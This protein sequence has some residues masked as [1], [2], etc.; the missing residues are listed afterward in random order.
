[1]L[2][3]TMNGTGT[4]EVSFLI[5]TQDGFPVGENE[6]IESLAPGNYN[7]TL[8][9]KTHP[10]TDPSQEPCEMWLP[11]NYTVRTGEL[12]LDMS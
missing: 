6:L 11:G 1:M 7:L 5:L 9:F 4:G 2:F 10:C 12:H 8:E 3:Q